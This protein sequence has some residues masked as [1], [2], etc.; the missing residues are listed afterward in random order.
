MAKEMT[1]SFHSPVQDDHERRLMQGELEER[2]LAFK[3]DEELMR[4]TTKFVTDVIETAAA[5]ANK[6]KQQ[7]QV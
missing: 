5:E 7:E 2:K 3:N 6:R 4:E 1:L